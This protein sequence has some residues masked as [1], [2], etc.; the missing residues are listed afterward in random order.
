[1]NFHNYDVYT[2]RLEDV[3]YMTYD[4]Y[5]KFALNASCVIKVELR[6]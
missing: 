6:M 4:I 1:M 5:K 2:L 3:V